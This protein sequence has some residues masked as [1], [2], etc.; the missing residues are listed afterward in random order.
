MG[1][2]TAVW[3]FLLCAACFSD[4]EETARPR[5]PVVRQVDRLIIDS[6]NPKALFDLFCGVLKL[7]QAWPLAENQGS[8][9]GGM[10][11]GNVLVEVYGNKNSAPQARYAGISLEPYPMASAL[12]ELQVRG[13]PYSPPEPYVSALPDG[14]R[15]VAWTTVP[16]PL[17]CKPGMSVFLYEYSPSFLKVEV[18]RNQLGN[19]LTLEGGGPLGLLSMSEIGLVT[20]DFEKDRDNWSRMLGAP[21]SA[22]VWSIGGGPAIRLSRGAADGIRSATF[23]VASLAKARAFLKQNRLLGRS[24]PAVILLDSA[25]TQGLAVRLVE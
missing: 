7:P 23:K 5:G 15:G 19:R 21:G 6:A 1:S 24:S 16:L 18:R 13:I 11:A 17:L 14:S 25:Q 9:S 2:K 10:G 4:P 20:T 3:A 22:A 12:R 8:L